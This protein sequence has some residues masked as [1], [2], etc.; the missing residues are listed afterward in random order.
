MRQKTFEAFPS[1]NSSLATLLASTQV[2]E[3]GWGPSGPQAF[4]RK[5]FARL[6]QTGKSLSQLPPLYMDLFGMRSRGG[7]WEM[8]CARRAVVIVCWEVIFS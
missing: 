1:R 6:A 3:K 8:P 4:R 7:S 2:G 5:L